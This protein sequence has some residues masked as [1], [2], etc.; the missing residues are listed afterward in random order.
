LEEFR[1]YGHAFSA[2][3]NP[4]RPCVALDLKREIA[5]SGEDLGEMEAATLCAEILGAGSDTTA[6]SL[7]SLVQACVAFPDVVKKAHEGLDRVVGRGRFATWEDEPNPL[8]IRAMI[9]EQHR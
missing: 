6:T 8:H 5:A 4:D 7:L 2:E 9:K 3:K 1:D